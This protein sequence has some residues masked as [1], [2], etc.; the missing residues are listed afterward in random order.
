MVTH[1]L[2]RPEVTFAVQPVALFMH[3][4]PAPLLV[5]KDLHA[6][7]AGKPVLQGVDLQIYP[8]EV[9]VLLGG[10][11]QGKSSL[12]HVLAGAPGYEV[13]R[14]ELTFAGESL[15][16]LTPEERARKGL[17]LAFQQP[18]ALPG[19][20]TLAFLK[21]AVGSLCKARGEAAPPIPEL[22]ARVRAGLQAVGLPESFLHRSIHEGFSGGEKRR[23]ELLLWWLLSPAL[24]LLDEIDSGLDVDALK[25]CGAELARRRQ[26]ASSLLLIT[27]Y[28]RLFAYVKPDK[29]HVMQAG[30]I[31]AS[32]GP[33]LADRIMA[34]GFGEAAEQ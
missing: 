31:I 14:G 20:S 2:S 22:L 33:E 15:A 4:P 12:V 8:G 19:V 7:V 9:H 6:E 28:P 29:V 5:I 10:N 11:G 16:E 23:M 26:P 18:V 13:T 21:A 17:F 3:T 25:Q 34:E 1:A 24:A 30:R 32:G 27:H